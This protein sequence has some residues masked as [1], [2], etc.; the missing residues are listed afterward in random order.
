[1][2]FTPAEVDAMGLWEFLSCLAGHAEARGAEG[3]AGE[4]ADMPDEAAL[5][6]M[7]IAG[8]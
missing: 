3:A 7:G 4:A 8:F 1:M 6:A 2:G 5:G